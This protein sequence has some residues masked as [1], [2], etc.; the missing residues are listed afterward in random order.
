MTSM[1]CAFTFCADAELPS[2]SDWPMAGDDDEGWRWWWGDG[3]VMMLDCVMWRLWER[4]ER[5]KEW[6]EMNWD[7]RLLLSISLLLVVC[8]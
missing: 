6:Y 4:V 2:S 5:R 7:E 8:G 3:D 1:T